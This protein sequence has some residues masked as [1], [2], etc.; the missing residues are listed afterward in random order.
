MKFLKVNVKE[1]SS[2][3]YNEIQEIYKTVPKRKKKK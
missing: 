1:K 2:P 3:I